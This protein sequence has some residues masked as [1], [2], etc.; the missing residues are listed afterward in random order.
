MVRKMSREQIEEFGQRKLKESEAAVRDF[1]KR[2]VGRRLVAIILGKPEE[3]NFSRADSYL[4]K[5]AKLT[6]WEALKIEECYIAAR[7]VDQLRYLEKGVDERVAR[8]WLMTSSMHLEDHAP[9]CAIRDGKSYNHL[10]AVGAA[11]TFVLNR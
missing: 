7:V 2:K 11:K 9:I 6:R 3:P 5:G 8:N 1:L 10:T 4:Y